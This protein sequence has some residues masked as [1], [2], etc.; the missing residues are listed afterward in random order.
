MNLSRRSML[1]AT[2]TTT[3]LAASLPSIADT[4]RIDGLWNERRRILDAIEANG[5]EIDKATAKLPAW[6]AP[7][8]ERIDS[9]GNRVGAIVGWPEVANPTPPEYPGAT[10]LIRPSISDARL[11]Y[12]QW[13]RMFGP[14]DRLPPEIRAKARAKYR[15]N[16]RSIIARLRERDQL[17]AQ[18]ELDTLGKRS[19]ELCNE[20]FGVE[21]RIKEIAK[22]GD[23]NA[24]AAVA[25]VL[26][27]YESSVDDTLP[28]AVRL[29]LSSLRPQL[30]GAV[31]ADI[32]ALLDADPETRLDDFPFVM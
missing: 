11:A 8:P 16:V 9:A 18:V 7:G 4:N 32:V 6:A 10:K 1:L 2:A 15:D 26:M 27:A 19:E 3:A 25:V 31:G 5:V 29:M 21:D 12:E 30:G 23:L 24:L 28:D 14:V 13:L 20:L 22:T 17:R